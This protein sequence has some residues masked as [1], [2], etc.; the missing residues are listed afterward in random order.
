MRLESEAQQ[1]DLW[2]ICS[3][4][5]YSTAFPAP[6]M[7]NFISLLKACVASYSR[8]GIK[9]EFPLLGDHPNP[10][11]KMKFLV[12]LVADQTLSFVAGGV[13]VAA[14]SQGTSYRVACWLCGVKG[15]RRAFMIPE[16]RA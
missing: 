12:S 6:K 7:N 1:P 8:V 4:S 13:L 15:H 5:L 16:G 9:V 11:L 14:G 10:L 2:N 3:E